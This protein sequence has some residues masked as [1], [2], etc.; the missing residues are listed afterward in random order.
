MGSIVCTYMPVTEAKCQDGNVRVLLN[1]RLLREGTE[2]EAELL[3][4]SAADP[5]SRRYGAGRADCRRASG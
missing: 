5:T 1:C 2:K 4:R 3:R